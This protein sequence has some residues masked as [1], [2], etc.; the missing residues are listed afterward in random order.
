MLDPAAP[1]LAAFTTCGSPCNRQ[2]IQIE[3]GQTTYRLFN[4][5]GDVKELHVEE[6]AFALFLLQFIGQG[7]PA[8]RQH[9]QADFIKVDGVAEARGQFKASMRVGHVERYNQ[10]V[11]CHGIPLSQSKT[12]WVLERCGGASPLREGR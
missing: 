7:K 5:G 9:P 1:S 8:S 3:L 6:N 12:L 4:R 10:S 2:E 11:I